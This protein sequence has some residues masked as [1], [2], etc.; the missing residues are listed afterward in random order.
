M[1]TV[2]LDDYTP[3]SVAPPD[4]EFALEYEALEAAG[5]QRA[6][7]GNVVFAACA[8]NCGPVLKANLWRIEQM[9]AQF[10]EW[11]AVIVE[12]DSTDGTKQILDEWAAADSHRHVIHCDNG[13]PHLHGFERERME[14]LAEYRN[15]YLDRIRDLYPYADFVVVLDL[16]V[17]G[18]YGGL[19]TSVAHATA[20]RGAYASVSMF[21]MPYG[22][23]LRWFH[24]DQ[25]AFRWHGWE[26][27][28]GEWFPH[29]LPPAGAEPIP[30]KSAFGGMT[31][32]RGSV[33]LGR[34]APRYLSRDGD[35][36]HVGLHWEM[37]GCG[38]QVYLN[39]SQ[40]VIVQ[41]EPRADGGSDGDDQ[42][43]VVPA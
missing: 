5:R 40:R 11:A 24:Y 42:R 32:Y 19:M 15:L 23:Q 14:A 30:V 33:L 6:K 20:K 31:L 37:S 29:W 8:R 26:R 13:R 3:D 18:G 2:C 1:P 34:Q 4:S 41:W 22:D 35:C 10:R 17:W 7:R 43:A 36:E 9:G 21:Q 16:D 28:F 12:N 38:E 27:R 39:P 25:F